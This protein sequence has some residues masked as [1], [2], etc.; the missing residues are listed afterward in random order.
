MHIFNNKAGSGPTE[1]L[2]VLEESIKQLGDKGHGTKPHT[3]L[4]IGWKTNQIKTQPN[5][6]TQ[7]CHSSG[8]ALMFYESYTVSIR[9]IC[10]FI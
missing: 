2:D 4:I 5:L 8:S 7:W 9:F 10:S 6:W 1:K 3:F